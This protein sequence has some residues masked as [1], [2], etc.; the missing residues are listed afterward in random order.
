MKWKNFIWVIFAA[1]FSVLS[2]QSSVLAAFEDTGTGARPTVMGGTYVAAGDDVQSLMYNPA[3]L[4]QL[5]T[6]EITSEY[7]RLYTGLTDGSN[8]GQYF[9]GYGQPIKYGG[10]LAFGW[11]QLDLD[12]LYTER[13]LSL[14][15][16]EW[17]TPKIAAGIAVKQLYHSFGA[18]NMIVDDNGNV[19]NGTPSFFARNGNSSTAYSTDLGILYRWTGR[20]TIGFSIQ[21]VNEPNIALNPDDHEIVSRTLRAGLSH[22]GFRGLTWA[23]SLTSKE[24]LSNQQDYIWTGAVEK[25]WDMKDMGSF[26]G[27]GSLATG[28]RSFQQMAMGGSYRYDKYQIDYAFVFNL[29]G[30][31]LGNTAGTHRFS[32]SYRFGETAPEKSRITKPKDTKVMKQEVPQRSQQRHRRACTTCSLSS[33]ATRRSPSGSTPASSAHRRPR[34]TPARPSS[35][36]TATPPS[37]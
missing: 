21:D 26:A 11:K 7:S 28:S 23:G 13:T 15:Y 20:D 37:P 4:A 24:S 29:T 27:R 17:I 3:G 33:T 18:P 22:R 10:T 31:S 1:A 8:L 19:Q 5:H 34:A 35:P 6:K 16:G 30:V 12:E 14:G 36:P 2:T 25:W 9:M 32:F